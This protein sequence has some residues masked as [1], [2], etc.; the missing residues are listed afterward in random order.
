MRMSTDH[1][2]ISKALVQA[3]RE[4]GPVVKDAT[5]PHFKNT[6][7]SLD[8]ITEYVKPLLANHGITIVQHADYLLGEHGSIVGI[9]VQT[10]LLHESG[11][12]VSVSAP[13]PM[14]KYDPQGAGAAMTYGRRYS[15]SAALAII[16]DEDD[17]A[18]GAIA[19]VSETRS[20][21][22]AGGSTFRPVAQAIPGLVPKPTG[23]LGGKHRPKLPFGDGKKK[24]I[25]LDEMP[26]KEL[27]KALKWAQGKNL[28]DE[29]QR[30]AEAELESR[31][32]VPRQRVQEQD[33]LAEAM[34]EL[35]EDDDLPF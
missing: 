34:G 21:G 8:A 10:T 30:E 25:Y 24:D 33:R 3:A 2:A 22:S 26:E 12:W 28:Y 7:A 17:D 35:D 23:G 19:R 27:A 15:L 9:D 13:M 18:E 31:R 14:A 16:T 32:D 6:Y 1:A 5:N 29:F 11:E 4:I 20:T